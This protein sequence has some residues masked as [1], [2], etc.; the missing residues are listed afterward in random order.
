VSSHMS[1]NRFMEIKKFIHLAD[2]EAAIPTDKMYEVS[3]FISALNARF[4]QF[5]I[6]HK[7]LSVDEEMVP[8]YGHHSAKMYLRGKPIRFRYKLWHC[9]PTYIVQICNKIGDST[10][11]LSCLAR[12]ALLYYWSGGTAF[13]KWINTRVCKSTRS[14]LLYCAVCNSSLN[15]RK[16]T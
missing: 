15:W 11:H 12:H 4:Q 3:S 10:L 9:S 1:R 2:N 8:Y 5:G 7:Y 13:S 16:C 14:M 6:F